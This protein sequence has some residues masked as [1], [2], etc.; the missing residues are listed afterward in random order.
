VLWEGKSAH[1]WLVYG[2]TLKC[3]ANDANSG[4]QAKGGPATESIDSPCRNEAADKA[5]PEK[6]AIGGTDQSSSTRV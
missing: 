1:H 4:C 5:S 2:R 3:A 6:D